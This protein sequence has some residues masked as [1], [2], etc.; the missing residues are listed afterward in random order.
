MERRWS[1]REGFWKS[2][3]YHLKTTLYLRLNY[4]KKKK[5]VTMSKNIFKLS[6]VLKT[7]LNFQKEFKKISLSLVLD[8]TVKILF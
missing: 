4:K 6:K 3:I 8:E 1:E 7:P 5:N 2:S